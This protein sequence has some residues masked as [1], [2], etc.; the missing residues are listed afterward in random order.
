M[1]GDMFY[2]AVSTKDNGQFCEQEQE[3]G[4]IEDFCTS[5]WNA[6]LRTYSMLLGDF[7]LDDITETTGTTLLFVMFTILGVVILLN[8]L[9]AVISDSYEKATMSGSLL[10]G[11]AR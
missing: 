6:Y 8:V 1:F 10:F 11:R 5:P 9:I 7:E 3:S 2:I 4:A